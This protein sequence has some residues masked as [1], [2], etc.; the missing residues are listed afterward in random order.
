[1]LASSSLRLHPHICSL[2]LAENLLVPRMQSFTTLTIP[3]GFDPAAHSPHNHSSSKGLL[4]QLDA[5][6]PI[7]HNS[8]DM[9]P[10]INCML[11]GGL[12][13]LVGDLLMHSLDTVKTR[14]Q[15]LPN[16]PAYHNMISAYRRIATTEGVFRGLYAGYTPA[17]L[18]LFPSTAAFFGTYEYSKRKMLQMQLPETV[19]FFIAGILGDFALSIFYVPSEVLKTRLQLQGRYNNPYTQGCGYNYRGLADAVRQIVRTEGW[20]ALFFGYKETLFR[21][22]P[23]SALQFAFYEKFRQWAIYANDNSKDLSIGAELGTGAAAGALAGTLTTPL[24]VIK[25][26]IQTATATASTT[27]QKGGVFALVMNKTSTGRA[28]LLIYR[29]EGIFGVFSGVGPRCIWTGVQ[30]SIMLLLYQVA[31]KRFDAY[32]DLED[33]LA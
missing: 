23:F 15:G 5:E 11:A 19:S 12:G 17:A 29:A 13:G 2:S 33:R 1:M 4:P 24:D 14:Q 8:D 7:D 27:V 30:S 10:I 31:L 26:R 3:V 16:N 28:I 21:D 18:G 9:L 22:L 25:T 6:D 20:R 32:M